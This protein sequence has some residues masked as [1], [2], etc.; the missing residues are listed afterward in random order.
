MPSPVSDQKSV[1]PGVTFL[2]STV[3]VRVLPSLKAVA[4]GFRA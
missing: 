1:V 2:V 4:E 3:V